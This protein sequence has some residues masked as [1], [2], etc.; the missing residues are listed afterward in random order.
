MFLY[1]KNIFTLK[2]YKWIKGKSNMIKNIEN[3]EELKEEISRLKKEVDINQILAIDTPFIDSHSDFAVINIP[4]Y[5]HQGH[6]LIFMA[7][8]KI[9]MFSSG[10]GKEMNKKFGRS[11]ISIFM[12]LR[13][14]LKNYSHE[15]VRIR[16]V[17]N[18]LEMD[19]VLDSIEDTGRI[20]RKLTDRME[21]LFQI[22]IE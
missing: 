11:T 17:M 9:L 12:L 7:D 21:G 2:I 20:L 15:F 1:I 22:I 6:N 3:I 13:A 5:G 8:D 10:N 19:P 14:V 4:S 16:E 18:T